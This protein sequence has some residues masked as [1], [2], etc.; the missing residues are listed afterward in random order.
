LAAP[1]RRRWRRKIPDAPRSILARFRIRIAQNAD[2]MKAIFD[3]GSLPFSLHKFSLA[4]VVLARA[5]AA[6]A[7]CVMQQERIVVVQ[8]STTNLMRYNTR[9]AAL[10][11]LSLM[12]LRDSLRMQM[13][14]LAGS[15]AIAV[16]IRRAQGVHRI[17]LVR[18]LQRLLLCVVAVHIS[19]SKE[20][21]PQLVTLHPMVPKFR[22][23]DECDKSW[24]YRN[25]RFR[26]QDLPRVLLRLELPEWCVMS[27]RA[28]L[29]GETVLLVSLFSLASPITQEQVA[30]EFGFA[31]QSIVSR[32][33][34]F[35]C[36]H[37][38]DRFGH[39]LQPERD[40]DDAFLRWASL[41]TIFKTRIFARSRD[42]RFADV[43][44][45]TDGTFRPTC[46]PVQRAE[47]A[48]AR[49]STQRPFYSGH[50]KRH[51]FKFQGVMLPNGLFASLH[52]SWVG[53]RNDGHLYRET[54]INSKVCA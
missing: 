17:Q 24:C 1:W 37:V 11:A 13:T 38:N 5:G 32:T 2:T 45:F 33:K 30:A 18:R 40:D 22:F 25:T 53:R 6:E 50:K 49:L 26:K 54:G 16:Q 46:R 47:D 41:M 3:T 28:T 15:A 31:D 12:E 27:N 8:R 29:S 20:L 9:D 14:L 36:S 7:S 10:Y 23:F 42:P 52:G 39:L 35:F 43:C 34:T 51:G 44:M 48:A 19:V 4:S 21:M